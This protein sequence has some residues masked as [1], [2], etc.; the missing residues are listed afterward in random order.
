M[1][2]HNIIDCE[3]V[4]LP[5]APVNNRIDVDEEDE[6]AVLI[7]LGNQSTNQSTSN[8]TSDFT[9][10]LD[11]NNYYKKKFL[12]SH[13]FKSICMYYKIYLDYFLYNNCDFIIIN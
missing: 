8:N 6:S 5:N 3:A 2:A 12:G 11:I 7:V 13:F 9:P 4:I 10:N 1:L